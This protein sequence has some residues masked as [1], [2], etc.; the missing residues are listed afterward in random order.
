MA[1]DL[2]ETGGGAPLIESWS[3]FVGDT[4]AVIRPHYTPDYISVEGPHAPRRLD[5]HKIAAPDRTDP[6]ALPSRRADPL[7][8]RAAAAVSRAAPMPYAVRNVEADEIHF[9]QGRRA[10]DRHRFRRARGWRG[11]FR[12][13][14]ARRDAPHRAA[15]AA[16]AV[17]DRRKPWPVRLDTPRRTAWSMPRRAP[18]PDR[19]AAAERRTDHSPHQDRDRRQRALLEA[20]RSGRGI[21]AGRGHV[22][23]LGDAARQDQP[24]D[25]R[26]T[27]GRP[28]ISAVSR[29]KGRCCSTR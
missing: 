5:I 28:G 1:D 25:L 6:E 23:G 15:D 13:H 27:A 3:R 4:A 21:G 12:L 14:P 10:A 7:Y 2:R 26:R 18:R 22:P 29:Q 8:R 9:I 24:A 17:A 11:G 20:A 16:H 19:G